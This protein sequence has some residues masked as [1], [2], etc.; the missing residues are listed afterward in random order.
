[1]VSS[2]RKDLAVPLQRREGFQRFV[3]RDIAAPVEKIE[4][5]PIFSQ[6]QQASVVRLEHPAPGGVLGKHL[7]NQK[8]RI[9]PPFHGFSHELFCAALAIHLGGIDESR[10][11]VEA[12]AKR[13]DFFSPDREVLAHSPSALSKSGP[14]L[15]RR[16]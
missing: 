3:Q 7:V 16:Q 9:A 11:K 1:M 2:P 13:F 14:S 5:D 4:V 15:P 10:P 12:R 6:A 8:D